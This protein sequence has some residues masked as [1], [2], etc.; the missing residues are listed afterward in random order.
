MTSPESGHCDRLQIHVSC[1]VQIE[2]EKD[3]TKMFYYVICINI[4]SKSYHN[5]S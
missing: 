5:R 3:D 2:N 4:Y 1:V